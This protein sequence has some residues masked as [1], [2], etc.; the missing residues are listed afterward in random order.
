MHLFCWN[1]ESRQG[2]A[3]ASVKISHQHRFE[4]PALRDVKASILGQNL[5]VLHFIVEPANKKK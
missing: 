4:E 2:V 1:T 3:A 5:D